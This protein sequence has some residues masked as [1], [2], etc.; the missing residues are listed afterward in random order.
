MPGPKIFWIEPEDRKE[1]A[2]DG[3]HGRLY[4][5]RTMSRHILASLRASEGDSFRFSDP[6]TGK[7]Y[8]GTL[9]SRDPCML[10]L[11]CLGDFPGTGGGQP[12]LGIAFSPLKGDALTA[13]VSMAVMSGISRLQPIMSERSVVRWSEKDGW[14]AKE[15][16]FSGIVREQSQLSGRTDRLVLEKPLPLETF[17]KNRSKDL[18]LWFDEDA[19][20]ALTLPEILD[21]FRDLPFSGR[22]QRTVWVV[23]GPEG[24]WS[25]RDRTMLPEPE[26][27]GRL[28]RVTLG[29]RTFSA[30]MALQASGAFLGTVLGPM[31]S[32][33]SAGKAPSA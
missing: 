21:K 33:A 29:E 26:R 30:E 24:G 11:K 18:F 3:G 23:V 32:L 7:T 17:L 22:E 4:P 16:R 2:P 9:I 20:D 31:F 14:A 27:E 10:E 15:N 25:G 28:F 8:A 6:G 12:R 19:G 1:L 5:G 13:V